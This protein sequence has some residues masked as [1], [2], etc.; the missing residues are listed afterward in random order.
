MA[1]RSHT[2]PVAGGR[3]GKD[4]RKQKEWPRCFTSRN[5]DYTVLPLY[6]VRDHNNALCKPVPTPIIRY[7][8]CVENSAHIRQFWISKYLFLPYPAHKTEWYLKE[9]NLTIVF[10]YLE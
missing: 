7:G 9:N 3:R 5:F 1:G 4:D 8:T 10:R 2:L 6:T